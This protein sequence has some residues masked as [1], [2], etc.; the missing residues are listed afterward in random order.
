[1]P[2]SQGEA[3][4]RA[5]A[6]TEAWWS[7]VPEA[8][9]S[10]YAEDGCITIN[11][12]KPSNGRGEVAEMARGFIGAFPDIIVHM[13]DIRSAGTHAVYRWTLEGQNTGP[14]GTGNYVKVRSY[15]SLFIMFSRLS[16]VIFGRLEGRPCYLEILSGQLEGRS[17]YIEIFSS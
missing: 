1:M 7:H 8:V 14:E 3:E 11:G 12:G 6:Y 9:S 15:S 2:S 13:D 10:F 5:K 4:E 17:S 16:V